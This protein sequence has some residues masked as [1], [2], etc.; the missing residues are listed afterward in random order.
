MPTF[1]VKGPLKVPTYDGKAAKI[2]DSERLPDFWEAS[3]ELG[4]CRGCYVFAI[5]ASKGIR[6]VYIGRA[7]KTF[8]QDGHWIVKIK[9]TPILVCECGNKY[10][11]TRA[12]QAKCLRCLAYLT[13][14]GR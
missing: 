6:P 11:K 10:L 7:T 1:V 8:Q 5:R 14:E 2:V 9:K 13:T 3:G 4:K 12:Q